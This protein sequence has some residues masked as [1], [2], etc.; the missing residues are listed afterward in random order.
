MKM[1]LQWKITKH[2]EIIHLEQKLANNKELD[3]IPRTLVRTN[4]GY[5]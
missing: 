1:G 5:N 4:V 3:S 2:K